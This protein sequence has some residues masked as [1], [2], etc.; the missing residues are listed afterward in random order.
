M[1]IRDRPWLEHAIFDKDVIESLVD[2][3]ELAESIARAG[4]GLEDS[5]FSKQGE[6]ASASR[7]L[8]DVTGLKFAGAQDEFFKLYR[9]AIDVWA[10]ADWNTVYEKG[11]G[12]VKLEVYRR[13][14]KIKDDVIKHADEDM[15]KNAR[16]EIGQMFHL[17]PELNCQKTTKA[18]TQAPNSKTLHT[19]RRHI[20]SVLEISIIATLVNVQLGR[21]EFLE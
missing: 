10:T 9:I 2:L 15:I 5:V 6:S 19:H 12:G 4:R 17:F 16:D 18:C 3:D 7:P 1:C 21:S 13:E 14:F 8:M 11:F 20:Q